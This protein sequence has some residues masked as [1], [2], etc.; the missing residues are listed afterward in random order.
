MRRVLLARI[1]AGIHIDGDQRFRLLDYDV[2]AGGERHLAPK[3]VPNLL[4]QVVVVED[5][6][7]LGVEGHSLEQLG[8]HLPEIG[9]DLVAQ[10][11]GVDREPVH[12]LAEH[13]A[14]DPRGELRLLVHERGRFHALCAPANL[15]PGL[16]E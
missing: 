6:G 5:R 8:V 11:L 16:L 7:L 13:I 4:F 9:A 1:A 12:A 14:D 10:L 2:P 15:V 3:R